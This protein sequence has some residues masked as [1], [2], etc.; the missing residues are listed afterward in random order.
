MYAA[1]RAGK[2]RVEAYESQMYVRRAPP[3]RAASA[4]LRRA[5]ERGE[6]VLALPADRRTS[7]PA[8]IDG[9]EALVRWEHPQFGH[10]LPQHFIPLAEETGLIVP[11]G[12]L[13]AARGLP[14][15]RGAGAASI[16]DA[17]PHA[18]R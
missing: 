9:V 17:A 18:S 10:L 12:Q 1:K 11:R 14:P 8:P 3:P 16:P 6:L 13:G 7:P 2:G 4:A 5:I 15:G